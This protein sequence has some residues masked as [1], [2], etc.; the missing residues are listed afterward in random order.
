MVTNNNV[1]NNVIPFLIAKEK[2][3]EVLYVSFGK[4]PLGETVYFKDETLILLNDSLANKNK[5]YFVMAHELY[6]ALEHLEMSAYYTN[7]RHGKG[8]YEREANLFAG[9]LMIKLYQDV[10]GFL[11]ESVQ[12]LKDSYGVP[13]DLKDD[14]ISSTRR[15]NKQ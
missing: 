9:H 12:V 1:K 11:P 2:G 13:I 3:I 5:R 4:T 8:K 6:H 10:F 7:Q 14:L 15:V